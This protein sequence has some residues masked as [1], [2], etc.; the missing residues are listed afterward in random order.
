MPYDVCS[1]KKDL[2]FVNNVHFISAIIRLSTNIEFIVIETEIFLFFL[3]MN[4]YQNVI[5]D[6]STFIVFMPF[7][8]PS[9]NKVYKF[10]TPSATFVTS[11][12]FDK[13][14]LFSNSGHFFSS[15]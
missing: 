4:K 3:K 13:Y 6:W 7:K 5:V 2:F 1:L 15:A 9:I 10:F 12:I 11:E 8:G 14:L